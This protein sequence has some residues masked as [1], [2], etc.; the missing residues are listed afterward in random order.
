M[1]RLRG[2]GQADTCYAEAP[3]LRN[4]GA[5]EPAGRIVDMEEKH[6]EKRVPALT[7]KFNQVDK[8]AH[9]YISGFIGDDEDSWF[10][11]YSLKNW[12]D[13]YSAAVA[14]GATQ[15][16]LRLNSEGGSLM[17]G[18][19]LADAIKA[20][21]I[22]VRCEVLGL[23]A[24]AATLVAYACQS[25]AV[26][27]HSFIGVH[28]PSGGCYGT[29]AQWE[30]QMGVFRTLRAKVFEKYSAVTGRSVEELEAELETDKIYNAQDAVAKGWAT[31]VMSTEEDKPEEKP[32]EEEKPADEPAD[33]PEPEDKPADG[34]PGIVARVLSLCGLTSRVE[35][36]PVTMFTKKPA[37][38]SAQLD[39]LRA[40]LAAAQSEAEAA[41][42]EAAAEKAEKA[43]LEARMEAAPAE[44][45]A[46]DSLPAAGEPQKASGP[47]PVKVMQMGGANA[48]IESVKKNLKA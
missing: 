7:M 12:Q 11:G 40:S 6:A 24:S 37:S 43:A 18:F 16:V 34:E 21:E 42:Q 30:Q 44:R 29:V 38:V 47:S 31:S 39:A 20:S 8:T 5:A 36:K 14:A 9:V 10:G 35:K 26:G 22:P 32:E 48:V 27:E 2:I 41:R 25:V 15:I 23:C 13:D 45:V 3:P 46:A 19:A 17:E 4:S 33:E 28:E 1:A